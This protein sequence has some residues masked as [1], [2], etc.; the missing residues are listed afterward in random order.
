[1]LS[2]TLLPV[3][4]YIGR[5]YASISSIKHAHYTLRFVSVSTSVQCQ[6]NNSSKCSNCCGPHAFGGPTVFCNK[7]YL[8]HYI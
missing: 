7:S 4:Q 6:I 8:L 1:M 2:S 3:D 5:L